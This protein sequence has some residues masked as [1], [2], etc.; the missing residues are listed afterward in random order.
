MRQGRRIEPYLERLFGYAFS[1]TRSRE[2]SADL[3]QDCALRAL[4][5]RR[6]PRDEAAYRA[7]LFRILRNAW[8]DR[9]RRPRLEQQGLP[10]EDLIA[11]ADLWIGDERRI[12]TLT[13]RLG[14]AKLTM[15]QREIIALVDI[16]GLSY[17]ETAEVLG[18]PRGTVMSRLSRARRALFEV[19]SQD[20]RRGAAAGLRRG[21]R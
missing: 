4:S 2:D 17:A 18:L 12:N 3:V 7:W 19:L 1:L 16:V 5:A 10:S 21:A 15:A 11:D 6:T 13:V 9:V 14:L 20:S 8:L